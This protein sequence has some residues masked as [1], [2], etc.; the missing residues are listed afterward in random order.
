MKQSLRA[1]FGRFTKAILKLGYKQS[2]W[3]HTLFIRHFVAGKIIVL[4]VYLDDI[5]MIRDDLEGMESLIKEFEIKELGKLK[6]F[7]GIEVVH[8]Q[9]GI[10]ISQ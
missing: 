7:L 10:F 5:L 9:Q 1:W 3:D 2:Q 4:L 8:S 6:Y